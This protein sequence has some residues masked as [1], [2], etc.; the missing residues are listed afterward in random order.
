MQCHSVLVA[1]FVCVFSLKLIA[2]V[3]KEMN[4]YNYLYITYIYY[5]WHLLSFL[6]YVIASFFDFIGR[7]TLVCSLASAPV[8]MAI[9]AH[10][11]VHAT[12]GDREAALP[13][14]FFFLKLVVAFHEQNLVKDEGNAMS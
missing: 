7:S 2:F 9:D 8:E 10:V 12:L 14:L 5:Y 4:C 6:C 3:N 1:L 13:T 11:H